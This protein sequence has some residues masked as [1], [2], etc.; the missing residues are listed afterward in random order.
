ML[1]LRRSPFSFTFC[2]SYLHFRSL[3]VV[4]PFSSPFI[5]TSFL[6]LPVLLC[7]IT[8][9]TFYSIQ[10]LSYTPS[11]RVLLPLLRY[12]VIFYIPFFSG[13]P[14]LT[15][16]FYLPCI[17]ASSFLLSLSLQSFSFFLTFIPIF[18]LICFLISF[19]PRCP[20][21]PFRFMLFSKEFS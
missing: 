8:F 21:F 4:D 10:Q 9:L 3:P 16:Y 5:L 7:L 12:H 13:L 1:K 20:T 6:T 15:L 19:H 11:C 14:F 17:I 18:R 2:N